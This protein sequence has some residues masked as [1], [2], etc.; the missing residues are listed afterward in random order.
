MHDRWSR[1]RRLRLG[2]VALA[3]VLLV[4]GAAPAAVQAAAA[5]ADRPS[6]NETM[7]EVD[8]FGGHV[9]YVGDGVTTVSVGAE[10][11]KA[12][13]TAPVAANPGDA[14]DVPGATVEAEPDAPADLPSSPT[15]D[16]EVGVDVRNAIVEQGSARGAPAHPD[17]A[18]SRPL[19]VAGRRPAWPHRRRVDGLQAPSR[20]PARRSCSSSTSSVGGVRDRPDGLDALLAD[21]TSSRWRSTARSGQLDSSTGVI[22]SDL[23][24]T[25][26]VLGNNFEGSTTGGR[27]RW[28]SSTPASTTS[29]TPSPAGSS[30]QACF[31]A[32]AL[33]PG[34]TNAPIGAPA[35]ATSARTR[36]T[37]TTAPTSAASPPAASSP[38]ATRAWPAA[39]G[40]SPIK[41]AQD[42]PASTRWTAFFSSIDSALQ[43]VLNLKTGHQPATS[44]RS[45]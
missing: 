31:V 15:A 23:L 33:L 40:S 18:R 11:E 34:G 37:A 27:T 35:A 21:P 17:P 10:V 24:N 22:D 1:N 8:T 4:I 44:S 16:T 30:R 2:T 25:A 36:P 5:G 38:A 28:R 19:G 26:G 3:A 43:H 29:T 13:G 9:G 14:E 7:A 42:S 20:A 6:P 45:T 39:P 41:V 32:D 12:E